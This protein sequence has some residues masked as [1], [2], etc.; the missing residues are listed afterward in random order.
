MGGGVF[1][2]NFNLKVEQVE[3]SSLEWGATSSLTSSG[4][5]ASASGAFGASPSSGGSTILMRQGAS[6]LQVPSVDVEGLE[7]EVA[8]AEAWVQGSV[9]V[10]LSMGFKFQGGLCSS[11][12]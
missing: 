11:S 9:R 8:A 12:S 6:H 2:F 1:H 4:V 5:S 3:G 7:G 10:V